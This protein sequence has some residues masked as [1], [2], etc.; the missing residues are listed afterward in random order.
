MCCS[1][2]DSNPVE[3]VPG[4]LMVLPSAG[5][6]L[7]GISVATAVCCRTARRFEAACMTLGACG[8]VFT[9]ERRRVGMMR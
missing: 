2:D 6:G 3:M 8:V 4:E 7:D 5:A 1:G 9:L